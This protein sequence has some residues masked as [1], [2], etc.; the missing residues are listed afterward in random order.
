MRGDVEERRAR[1][2]VRSV[3]VGLVAV[4]ALVIVG[5][6]LRGEG[7]TLGQMCGA[8]AVIGMSTPVW[9]GIRWA[10]WVLVGVV[11]W[12]I[13]VVGA[14]ALPSF[15]SGDVVRVG[16]LGALAFYLVAASL[17]ASP[18]AGRAARADG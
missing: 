17:L 7:A 5:D 1:W 9:Y 12:R 16:A 13:A 15:G 11:G 6:V 2:L 4:D 14:A 3:V 10:R 18:M 8:V